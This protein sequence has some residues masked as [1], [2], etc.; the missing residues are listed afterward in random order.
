[1]DFDIQE[2]NEIAVDE[3]GLELPDLRAA[4]VEAA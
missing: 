4:E 1:M 2:N 3:Q